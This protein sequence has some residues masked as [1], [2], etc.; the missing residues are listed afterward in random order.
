MTSPVVLCMQNSVISISNTRGPSPQLWFLDAKQRLYGF[1]TSPVV[2]C[3]QYNV[4]STRM[5]CLYRSQPLSV[6]FAC[7]TATFGAELQVCMGPWPHLSFCACKTV[8]LASAL[9][10]VPALNCGLCIQNS[11][12]RTKIECLYGSQTSLV[13]FCIENSVPSIRITSL[14][15]S[16]PSC[17]VFGCKTA[18]FGREL[19][20]SESQM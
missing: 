4:I 8:W 2:L 20:V 18:N 16:Q 11:D 5:T 15:R 10:G 17:G 6:V 7:K 3:M 14:Y 13:I 9:L 1:Q 12:L 19:K